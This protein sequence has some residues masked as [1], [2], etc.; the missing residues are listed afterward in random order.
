M[1]H[2][3]YRLLLYIN[4]KLWCN[5]TRQ[6]YRRW[7]NVTAD[8]N[9]S[10]L[11]DLVINNYTV[12]F[13][14]YGKAKSARFMLNDCIWNERRSLNVCLC[15]GWTP[16]LRYLS[17]SSYI[18]IK[19]FGDIN[20]KTMTTRDMRICVGRFLLS[21]MAFSL[22][23]EWNILVTIRLVSVFGEACVRNTT[24]ALIQTFHY[25]HFEFKLWSYRP[26]A[27]SHALL[28]YSACVW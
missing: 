12:C 7:I 27:L 28:V 13:I 19:F 20:K 18:V 11:V 3:D 1:L 21:Q 8:F 9:N 2:H 5:A 26:W 25:Y 17:Y 15:V 22:N 23:Y 6:K 14:P 4:I 24:G 10:S 16:T